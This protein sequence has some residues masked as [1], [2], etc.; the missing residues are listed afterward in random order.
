MRRELL[1]IMLLLCIIVFV[2]SAEEKPPRKAPPL[3]DVAVHSLGPQKLAPLPPVPVPPDNPQTPMKILLG[4]QLYF[5]T[6]LSADNNESCASCHDPAM[7][8]S[9]K[10]PTSVGIK[11]QVGPRRAPPV[12]NSA[13]MPLQFWDGRADTLEEQAKGP[14]INPKEM[15]NTHEKMLETLNSI[16]GYVEEFETVFGKIPID[17]DQVAKA[18]A[19]YERTIV[20]TDS[21][22]D[23]YAKG[24]KTALTPL[25]A[26]GL[27]IFNGK[28]HCTACH[29]G[30]NF[31][32]GRF[33]NLGAKNK[34]PMEDD[35]GRYAVTKNDKDKRAFKTPTV[36][37]VASRPPYLHN[38]SEQ[39]LWDLVEFYNRG[40]GDDDSN[41]DPLMVPLGLTK[42]EM[43]ALV[44]F[45]K[46]AVTSNNP[47]V[48]NEKP[49]P[50]DEFPK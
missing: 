43:E 21:P 35:L 1:S 48:A 25:E 36:R 24:D 26:Q 34:E 18:I 15:G 13:Y 11:S 19:A 40:G 3:P 27:E 42:G 32:D 39:T 23:R 12:S 2:V 20:T 9:D 17:L 41:M 37:D 14:I 22:F 46:V 8:W 10:G 38:G 47:E 6:R 44:A 7:G 5:D 50:P 4:K 33:H 30:P 31:T 45:M 29:W 49:I 16:P 28:G